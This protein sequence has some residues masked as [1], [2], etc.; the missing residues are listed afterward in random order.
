MSYFDSHA[1]FTFNNVKLQFTEIS[2]K[3]NN[4]IVTKI[5]ESYFNQEIDFSIDKVTKITSLLQAA[6]EEL[7]IKNSI[8]TNSASFSLPPELFIS[9]ML[10]VEQSLLHSDLIEDFKLRLEIMFPHLNW[11]EYV[12][13]YIEVDSTHNDPKNIAIVFA[14]NRRFIKIISD[15]CSKNG[16]K[17]KYID[18]CHLAS[19]NLLKEELSRD[20]L[21]VFISQ[22][23][24]SFL[25]SKKRKPT[26]Y[27]DFPITTLHQIPELIKTKIEGLGGA[28]II[29]ENLYLFGDSI[30]AS[31]A[32]ILTEKTGINFTLVNP[33]SQLKSESALLTNKLYSENNHLFT[34][35]T[36]TALRI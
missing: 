33:F 13:K 27:E 12:I 23:N 17:L 16:L 1:G 6:F 7:V 10:P 31:L 21:S 25:L 30:S 5:D 8:A 4:F 35:S 11:H 15:F 20:I 34:T 28:E 3:Q 14:L 19:A 29:D 36:G 24:L 18:H 9:A 2:K 26:Y 32:N 22:K